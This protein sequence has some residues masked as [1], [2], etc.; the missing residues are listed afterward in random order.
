MSLRANVEQK[1]QFALEAIQGVAVPTTTRLSACK[2]MLNPSIETARTGASGDYFDSLVY[3]VDDRTEGEMSGTPSF[4]DLPAQLT[5][6]HG[7]PTEV[8]LE[9]TAD[10]GQFYAK[11]LTFELGAERNTWTVEQGD[12]L[13][14]ER[15]TAV[16][17]KS[18]EMSLSPGKEGTLTIGLEG[19]P[20][21]DGVSITPGATKNSPRPA[22]AQN[23]R[24]YIDDDDTQLGVT[25]VPVM[26][27][28]FSLGDIAD[29]IKQSGNVNET[30]N[31]A[32][33]GTVELKLEVDAVGRQFLEELRTSK[34]KYVRIEI[35]GG[36]VPGSIEF[37][38]TLTIDCAVQG[39]GHER[40]E[41]EAVYAATVTL[42][43]VQ[44]AAD[45]AHRVKMIVPA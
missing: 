33:D 42:R 13:F 5:L 38:E 11:E 12:G 3:V 4:S 22:L 23:M 32:P 20:L 34:T 10:P 18:I 26:S 44:N 16:F 6:T 2:L 41:E 27:V 39:E 28:G 43:F 15:M 24:V 7:T 30:V 14:G 37:Y 21:E 9:E 40:G 35:V 1:A 45:F 31:K 19:G 8:D 36:L 17:A 25:E 29:L